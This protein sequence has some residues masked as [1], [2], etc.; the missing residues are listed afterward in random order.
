MT[1]PTVNAYYNPTFNEIVFP[2]GILQ[3]P[4]FDP[5]ADD[6]M[7]YGGIG[8]VIGHEMTHGFDD[9]GA[10]YDKDGN[11]KNWWTKEDGIKF[12]DKAQ[13]VIDLYNGFIV[14]DS[15]HLNGGTDEWRKHCGYRGSQYRL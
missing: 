6:A 10:Q 9:Q 2:A 15:L 4:L 14:L 13:R 8:T 12:H 11:L 5:E 1:A 3:P 7:N